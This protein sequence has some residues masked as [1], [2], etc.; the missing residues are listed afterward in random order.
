MSTTLPA[1]ADLPS[2]LVDCDQWVCWTATERD[3]KQTKI[4]V[5]PNSG[6]YASATDPKTWGSF[7]T[8]HEH[9]V[10][11]S[12][13]G[14]GFVFTDDDPFVGVDL[15]DCRDVE[16]G[17]G[18]LWAVSIVNRLDSYTEV[19]PSGTGYH[20]IIEGSLP[21]GGNR[22]GDL[23][24]YESARFFTMTGDRVPETASN[25]HE[26]KE[27]L[28][29]IHTEHF[30]TADR[31][32]EITPTSNGLD[33]DELRS[34]AAAAANGEK[35]SRLFRGDIAGY[36]SNSEADMALSSILAFWSGGD[37]AQI[38][39]LFRDSGLY[40]PKWDDVHFADGSTYGE[41]TV[42]RAI[43]GTSEFYEPPKRD[44]RAQ[45]EPPESA[46]IDT[47]GEPPR[48]DVESPSQRTE[49]HL[50][51]IATLTD[52]LETVV[53]E[54][55]RLQSDLQAEQTRRRELEQ[56]IEELEQEQ[57]SSGSILDWIRR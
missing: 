44:E 50:D 35:F 25:V 5:D 12:H 24:L 40:R 42:E 34:K 28:T 7:E 45:K 19:S 56:R 33:D 21:D 31:D 55:E 46:Q 16:T 26:R 49:A 52:E 3:G 17:T 47:R 11:E 10:T 20:V 32:Q 41:K 43:Q 36:D 51:R 30:G 23:E 29:E 27:S 57:A 6:R 1:E 15:D 14:L 9:A 53:A 48:E 8:A 4:P 54:N 2:P 18:D 38:D 22:T 39:R 13:L 37:K